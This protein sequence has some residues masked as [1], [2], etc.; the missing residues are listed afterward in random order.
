MMEKKES[1]AVEEMY[2]DELMDHYQNPRNY[3]ELAGAE[4]RYHDYNP[5]CGDEITMQLKLENGKVREAKFTGRGCAISQAAASM[6][7]ENVEGKDKKQLLQMKSEEMLELLKI[8]P[9]P[10]RIKC[11]LLALR[12]LQKGIIEY[13]ARKT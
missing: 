7:T 4:V 9:G 5:V 8:N 11:A 13:E 2:R 10:V 12:A 6:L 1:N 3:G